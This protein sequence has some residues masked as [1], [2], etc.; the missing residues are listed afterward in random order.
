MVVV[1][2]VVVVVVDGANVVGA[3]VRGDDVV[4]AAVVRVDFC[5]VD[6]PRFEVVVRG[7][8]VAV[9]VD[10]SRA[11]VVAVVV[12]GLGTTATCTVGTR[13]PGS[14]RTPRYSRPRPTNATS[15][16]SVDRRIPSRAWMGR[17][18]QSY[19]RTALTWFL[20]RSA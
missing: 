17:P 6:E 8:A 16:S 10:W 7:G 19:G 20:A 11:L 12:D 9:V 5:V 13:G 3:V 2:V 4:G 1:D 15:I 14:V 18:S